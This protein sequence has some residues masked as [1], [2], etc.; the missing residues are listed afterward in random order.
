MNILS[1]WKRDIS[2]RKNGVYELGIV[3]IQPGETKEKLEGLAHKIKNEVLN[4][5]TNI[6]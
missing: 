3:A 4:E 6:N 2:Q 1:Y 5:N